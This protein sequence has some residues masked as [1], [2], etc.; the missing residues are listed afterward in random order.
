MSRLRNNENKKREKTKQGCRHEKKYL[1]FVLISLSFSLLYAQD[2]WAIAVDGLKMRSSPN[3]QGQ[4]SKLIPFGEK[5]AIVRQKSEYFANPYAWAMVNW[6]GFI[7]WVYAAF[8]SPHP[9]ERASVIARQSPGVDLLVGDW[10]IIPPCR[11]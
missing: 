6:N 9:V 8:L 3:L 7:G 11:R 10:Y 5:V 4:S 2:S 1:V